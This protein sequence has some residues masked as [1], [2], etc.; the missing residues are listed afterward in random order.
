MNNALLHILLVPTL[1]IGALNATPIPRAF[2]FALLA[3]QAWLTTQTIEPARLGT[4]AGY[5]FLDMHIADIAVKTAILVT[6][7][8]GVVLFMEN[9]T[10]PKSDTWA[11]QIKEGYKMVFNGRRIG[12]DR[13]APQ[14]PVV[15]GEAR[16]LEKQISSM[17]H[18]PT[19]SFHARIRTIRREPRVRFLVRRIVLIILLA[20]IE[21]YIKP[22]F[23]R[24]YLSTTYD[25]FAPVKEAFFRRLLLPGRGPR[26]DGHELAVRL[27]MTFETTW[28]AYSFYTIWH[29]AASVLAVAT[30]LDEPHEWP[31]LFG[32]IRQAYSMRRYW[33]K[34][35][36]RLIYRTMAG[37]A[38]LVGRWTGLLDTEGRAGAPWRRWVL[39]GIIFMLSG[40]FHAWASAWQGYQC[41]FWEEVWWWTVNYMVVVGETVVLEGLQRSFPRW[42]RQTAEGRM[43]KIV[44]GGWVFLFIFWASPKYIY[45][46]MIC[47][48]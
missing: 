30:G 42:Y 47:G 37:Y 24:V 18:Q 45:P 20:M 19:D 44:G 8:M 11:G 28:A 34:F 5:P 41:G 12:T 48:V 7:H 22:R 14:V 15:E 3:H 17:H 16:T 23:L 38:K 13:L 31:P 35:F 43:A 29:S 46:V 9:I 21:F 10:L 1:A 32:D 39:N 27:W 36:D 26:P 6:L 40:V 4:A 33:V 25:D 2:L